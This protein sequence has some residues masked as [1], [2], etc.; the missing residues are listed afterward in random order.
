LT[1]NEASPVPTKRNAELRQNQRHHLAL[2]QNSKTPFPAHL[3]IATGVVL[4]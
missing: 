3:F 2:F 1:V 4:V